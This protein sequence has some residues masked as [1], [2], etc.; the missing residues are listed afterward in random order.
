[1]VPLMVMQVSRH[2]RGQLC[3]NLGRHLVLGNCES[4]A[5]AQIP[6]A[7]QSAAV[8]KFC[9]VTALRGGVWKHERVLELHTVGCS[10]RKEG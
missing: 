5:G 6:A 9:S 3:T 2:R 8:Q 7:S 10:M 1:M 4:K